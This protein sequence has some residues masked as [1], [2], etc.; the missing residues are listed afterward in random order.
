[1][2]LLCFREDDTK[3]F[4]LVFPYFPIQ[5]ANASKKCLH[6]NLT[7]MKM[8]EYIDLISKLLIIFTAEQ[9]YCIAQLKRI[10][11]SLPLAMSPRTDEG[12]NGNICTV[13]VHG[14]SAFLENKLIS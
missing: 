8:E 5:A 2:F 11:T 6:A 7:A 12:R 10:L 14:R 9:K 4:N 13:C 3:T 1:M